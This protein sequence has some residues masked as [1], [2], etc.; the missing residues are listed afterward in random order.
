MGKFNHYP[1]LQNNILLIIFC[2]I[3]KSDTNAIKKFIEI[4]DITTLNSHLDI[5]RCKLRNHAKEIN[6]YHLN[7]L[8]IITS[9]LIKLPSNE[10][11]NSLISIAYAISNFFD[12][13]NKRYNDFTNRKY[14]EIQI[15][16]TVLKIVNH[17]SKN[18]DCCYILLE[19]E[20]FNDFI[21]YL[22]NFVNRKSD[23]RS[24]TTNDRRSLASM[25]N[26]DYILYI[27]EKKKRKMNIEVI[28]KICVSILFSMCSIVLN[29]SN[30]ED[31]IFDQ[32]A[33]VVKNYFLI[34]QN[35][36]YFKLKLKF[37]IFSKSKFY[38]KK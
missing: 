28:K 7:I 15:Q 21:S 37:K 34:F 35:L 10:N 30:Q 13:N 27:T 18:K 2:I 16:D 14:V 32:F 33:I 8:Y 6:N 5:Y 36:K 19:S 26:K 22:N 12:K 1:E 38:I 9:H 4:F 20:F 31:K 24:E 3:N 29:I 23:T 11:G 17:L 25:K